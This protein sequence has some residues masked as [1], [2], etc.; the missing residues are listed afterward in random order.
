MAGLDGGGRRGQRDAGAAPVGGA[1][2]LS[3]SEPPARDG[4]RRAEAAGDAAGTQAG[5]P[6]AGAEA[7]ARGGRG[8]RR[9]ERPRGHPGARHRA[10]HAAV[11]LRAADRR[12]AGA[13]CA[14]RAEAG[15][16]RHAAGGRQ[17]VEGTHRAGAAGCARG[18]RRLAAPPPGPATRFPAVPGHARQAAGCRGGATDIEK[19][20]P[21]ERPARARH[22]ARA[23]AFLRDASAGGGG[24]STVDPGSAGACEFVDDAA[25][26]VGGRGEAA[27]GV[28]PDASSG[29]E[30]RREGLGWIIGVW[31]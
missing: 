21:A 7:G 13:G 10:V 14:R 11:R 23:A 25:V 19:F 8:D 24:G 12:G 18:D 6:R 3:L 4:E 15:R 26:H 20:P 5:A 9:D 27:G 31:S 29:V 28:S 16:D 17:G 1:Q 2:L 22:A 30:G